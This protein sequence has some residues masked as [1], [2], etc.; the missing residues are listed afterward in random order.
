MDR[1]SSESDMDIVKFDFRRVTRLNSKVNHFARLSSSY[2]AS[3]RRMSRVRSISLQ[4]NRFR[5]HSIVL[6]GIQALNAFTD[7]VLLRS[8][9]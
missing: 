3:R 4:Q 9:L 5:D 8:I 1:T 7:T 6:T 2:S